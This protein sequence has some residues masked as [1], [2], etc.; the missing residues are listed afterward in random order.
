MPPFELMVAQRFVVK[1][2]DD[3]PT[4][5]KPNAPFITSTLQQAASTRMGFSVKE[6]HEPWPSVFYE[7]GYI[8]YMRTD[9]TNL[10]ADSVEGCRDYIEKN[11]GPDYLPE[12]VKKV[13]E[14]R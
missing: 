9:S 3:R 2:R 6:N 10:S 4:K 14:Q 13:L 12:T 5:T 11:F 1:K 8:T 7:A